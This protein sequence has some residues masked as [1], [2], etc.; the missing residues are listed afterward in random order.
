V[1]DFT[2]YVTM[3]H[4]DVSPDPVSV[5]RSAMRGD[6]GLDMVQGK[7]VVDVMVVD[8]VEAPSENWS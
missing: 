1:I 4:T 6:L 7:A 8:H 3:E 2:S 5:L